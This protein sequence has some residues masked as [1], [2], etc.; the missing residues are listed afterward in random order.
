MK[1]RAA[2]AAVGAIHVITVLW[3]ITPT[4]VPEAARGA[5]ALTTGWR[6]AAAISEAVCF[7]CHFGP[8]PRI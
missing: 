3:A 6:L 7:A 4:A 2:A 5:F 1:P 8:G